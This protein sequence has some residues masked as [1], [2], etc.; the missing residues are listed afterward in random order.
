MKLEFNWPSCFRRENVDGGTTVTGIL[1]V[2]LGT[3]GSGELTTLN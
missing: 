1:I 3:F 2:Y